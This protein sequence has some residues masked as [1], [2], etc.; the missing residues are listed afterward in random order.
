MLFSPPPSLGAF[1]V[2]TKL[3]LGSFWVLLL[4][5]DKSPHSLGHVVQVS[6]IG[7]SLFCRL[8]LREKKLAKEVV[9]VMVG[10]EKVRTVVLG[11]CLWQ[12]L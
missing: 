5:S 12:V 4:N 3:G 9:V 1:A 10:P 6:V 7:S 2:S 11:V 8:R